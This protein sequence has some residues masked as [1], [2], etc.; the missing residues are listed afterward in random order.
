M[1]DVVIGNKKAQLPSDW[2]EL[3]TSQLELL[4]RISSKPVPVETAKLYIVLNLL[5]LRIT[6]K[7]ED[8]TFRFVWRHRRG[9]ITTEQ[10]AQLTA[11]YDHFYA[12]V[13]GKKGVQV[14]RP[15]FTSDPYPHLCVMVYPFRTPGDALERVT[16]NQFAYAHT[17]TVELS[18]DPSVLPKLLACLWHRSRKWDAERVDEDA[19]LLSRL[20]QERQMVMFWYWLGCLSAI[21]LLF[22]RIF[23]GSGK[24]GNPFEEQQR[25]IDALADGDMTKKDKVRSGLLYDALF[26]MDEAIRKADDLRKSLKK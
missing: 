25:V 3:T 21:R 14:L 18:S 13:E 10:M 1:R 8:D 4:A 19:R 15:T 5:G 6:R 7:V 17:F 2:S 11:V 9:V 20:S 23:S 16:Y 12:D 24:G 22:P 26:S